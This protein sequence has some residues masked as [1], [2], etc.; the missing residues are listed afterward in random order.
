[1]IN[2]DDLIKMSDDVL[3]KKES[4]IIYVND[5]STWIQMAI[6][7]LH[8]V[9][10]DNYQLRLFN[11]Q[12]NKE[13]VQDFYYEHQIQVM[14]SILVACKEIPNEYRDID[15]KYVVLKQL[16]NNFHK[17]VSTSKRRYDN[18][19]EACN[20]FDDEYDIQDAIHSILVMLFIN[21][22]KE[23]YVPSYGG[24][25]SRIDF[26]VPEIKLAI[27][28]KMTGETHKQ[29][30]IS[31]E[32]AIDIQRYKGNTQYEHILFFIYDP[33]SLL[34]NPGGLKELEDKNIEIII[35]P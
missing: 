17:Y 7:Y 21:V 4:D 5:A 1:M 2:I 27:E 30:K 6:N 9:I 32:I 11:Q 25:N 12:L 19:S 14:R 22:K 24:A 13:P 33:R 20:K 34:N 35:N 26:F 16:F 8:R 15:D 3:A 10:K 18:R 29:K 23:D 31:E 28:V